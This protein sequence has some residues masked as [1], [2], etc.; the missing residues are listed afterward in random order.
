MKPNPE[1]AGTISTP[2]N[3][4][5]MNDLDGFHFIADVISIERSL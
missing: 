4:A 1:M 3:T 5:V 2:F